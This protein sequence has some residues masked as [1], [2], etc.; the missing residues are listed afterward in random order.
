MKTKTFGY[1]SDSING[2]VRHFQKSRILLTA[3]ELGIFTIL[4]K[5]PATSG[6]VAK[7]LS[8]DPRATDRLLN[9]ACALGF[10]H[11]NNGSFNNTKES[12][13]FL[14]KG[15]PEYMAGLMHMN[16]LW[17]TWTTL[18]DSVR[19][20]SSAY[21]RPVPSGP[22]DTNWLESFIGAMHYRGLKQAPEVIAKIDRKEVRR[23]LDVGGGSGVFA[24]SFVQTSDDVRA[25][26]FDLPDVITI[27]K[28]YL[29][30]YNLTD[31]IDTSSG[32]YLTDELPKGYDLVFLSA[33]IHSNS[34]KENGLLIS[35][36]AS[37]LNP[38]GQLVIHDLIMNENRTSPSEG[39]IFALNMLVGT[40]KGDTYTEKEIIE[41]FIR[42][43]LVFEKRVDTYGGNALMTAR[44]KT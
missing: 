38:G 44:K 35:K 6:E 17:D 27:T 4:E 24:M 41:W 37:S 40:E 43:G 33:I 5:S 22:Q 1:S 15:K 30:Q 39:A 34:Y 42:A 10:L 36:S 11:K 13:K 32:D 2:F 25:T 20:G 26:V 21:R 19:K 29:R 12:G 7:Q 23:V 3:F 28:R 8:T 31:K 9:A 18:T 14:V 16:N